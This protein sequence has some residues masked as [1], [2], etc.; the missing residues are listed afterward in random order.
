ML[1]GLVKLMQKIICNLKGNTKKGTVY[2]HDLL[3][4]LFMLPFIYVS[5]K[6]IFSKYRNALHGD[7]FFSNTCIYKCKCIY[8][9]NEIK[10]YIKLE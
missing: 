7:I 3:I 8:K 4:Y 6:K 5:S 9:C 1:F 10:M 2:T